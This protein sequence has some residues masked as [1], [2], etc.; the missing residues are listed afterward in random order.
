MGVTSA[1]L[2]L[3]ALTQAQLFEFARS[4][5]ENIPAQKKRRSFFGGSAAPIAVR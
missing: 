3:G 4:L 2:V 1:V 5:G